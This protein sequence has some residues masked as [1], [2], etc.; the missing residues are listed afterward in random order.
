MN[1]EA[2]KTLLKKAQAHVARIQEVITAA[3][4][5]KEEARDR[6][7]E[8][9]KRLA[10]SDAFVERTIVAHQTEQ[11]EH[12]KRLIPSP[13]FAQCV[14]ETSG[15]TKTIFIAKH[16]FA[17]ERIYSWVTP[18]AAL[19]FERLGTAAYVRPDGTKQ[20]GILKSKDQYHIVD[21]SILFYATESIGAPRELIHQEHFSRHKSGFVLPEVVE[22]MERAQDQVIRAPHAGPFVISGPA[23]SGKTTLALHR[24]AYLLQ[25]P[26]TAD[27][28]PLASLIVFV[29]DEGTKA[30]FSS[31]LPS[32]GINGVTITTFAAWALSILGSDL[33]RYGA[34]PELNLD[35][36]FAYEQA[37]LRA[38]SGGMTL[39]YSPKLFNV[40]EET[41]GAHF[42]S[43]QKTYLR[44]QKK[45]SLLDRIDLTLLLN[46]K[47]RSDGELLVPKEYFREL[48]N[49]TYRKERGSFPAKYNLMIV[50]EFQNYLPEQL[51]LLKSCLNHRLDAIVY[52]G[53]G[54][55]RTE[56]GAFPDWESIDEHIPSERLVKL[57]KVYRTTRQILMY[58]QSL[59]YAVTIPAGIKEGPDV[60]EIRVSKIDEMSAL[61][62]TLSEKYSSDG[63][64]V[65]VLALEKNNLAELK[66][67]FAEKPQVHCL[68]F[69][70][71]QGVEFDAVV[72]I[73][74][75]EMI[76]VEDDDVRRVKR[77]LRYVGLT[78]AMNELWV[79]KHG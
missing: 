79:I 7:A 52:V 50:D 27:F 5:V 24:V 8:G 37:K 62:Q 32:L 15:E 29:Q 55:Q 25:S 59:G 40:L 65:G 34:L 11:L 58:I 28:F 14:F 48:K 21:S 36:R 57:E 44:E 46:L 71:A 74:T 30:Y 18:I 9:A 78:R 45:Q 22:Q 64:T 49:G 33:V 68:S 10:S 53:D 6:R 47:Y 13:Y 4:A 56:L 72:V 35:T 73:E 38:M 2:K 54:A 51:R 61:I 20:T 39:Q 69:H 16:S 17:D 66:Q 3:I 43:E 41:Y 31:L 19:R 42:T 75:E 12:L 63:Q 77:D 1:E 67:Y 26:E 23:G 70:E 60:R 76:E